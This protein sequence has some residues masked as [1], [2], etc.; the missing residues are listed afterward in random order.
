LSAKAMSGVRKLCF[1][2]Q[3]KLAHRGGVLGALERRRPEACDYQNPRRVR[4]DSGKATGET[5]RIAKE[6]SRPG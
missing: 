2:A 1:R 4:P 3:A 5:C 6:V